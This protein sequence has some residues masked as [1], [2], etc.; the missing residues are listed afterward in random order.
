MTSPKALG[1]ED[2]APP[3]LRQDQPQVLPQPPKPL[4]EKIWL[5]GMEAR[6]GC[7]PFVPAPALTSLPK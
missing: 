7:Q 1:P 2:S 5:D 3:G 4:P 6:M